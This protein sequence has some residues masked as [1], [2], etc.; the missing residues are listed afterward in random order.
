MTDKRTALLDKLADYVLVN[1]IGAANLRPM[2][3][4]VDTSDRMLL[5]YFPD[6]SALIEA[7]LTHI[8]GRLMVMFS[9]PADLEKLPL[10][11]LTEK[12][13]ARMISAPVWPYA[14]LWLEITA[15]AAGGDEKL[16]AIGGAIGRGFLDWGAGQLD[17]AEADRGK[18]AA[19]LMIGVEGRLVLKSLGLNDVIAEAR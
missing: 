14:R 2:A 5:Y 12:I 10:A 16:E 8:A 9:V 3:K 7:V 15:L 1:G 6:K 13:Y 17:C 18:Q 11:E 19:Q 4:A